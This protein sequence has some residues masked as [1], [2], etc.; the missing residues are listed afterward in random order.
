MEDVVNIFA[1]KYDI[2]YVEEDIIYLNY[3]IIN[4]I[5]KKLFLNSDP[6]FI[7]L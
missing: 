2:N 3:F 6:I 4:Y 5:L 1:S 7:N